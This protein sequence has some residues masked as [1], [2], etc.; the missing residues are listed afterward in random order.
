[1]G[2]ADVMGV[3]MGDDTCTEIGQ[4]VPECSHIDFPFFLALVYRCC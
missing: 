3:T 4:V 2:G 1:M